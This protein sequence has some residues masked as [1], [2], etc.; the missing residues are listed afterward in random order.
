MDEA[1]PASGD[2]RHPCNCKVGRTIRKREPAVTDEVLAARWRGDGGPRRSLRDLADRFNESLVRATMR[3]AGMDP[4]DGEAENVYRL[5]TDDEVSTG[6]RTQT[7][8]RLERN[9]VDIDAL[10]SD[11][12]SHQT[13]HTHLTD[14][15]SVSRESEGD[16]EGRLQR[17]NDRIQAL[18]NRVIAVT[19]DTLGRLDDEEITTGDVDV[20]TTISVRCKDCGTSRE[21]NE[22]LER[23]GCECSTGGR[24]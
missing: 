15:L 3:S 17:E 16:D 19:E 10:Q 9:G 7:A 24:E 5:L 4:L 21:V 1:E 20:F 13:I 23:G 2:S 14:C 18:R 11:F 22:L 8:R 6:V 12:V